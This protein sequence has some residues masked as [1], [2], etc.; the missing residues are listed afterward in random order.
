MP[1]FKKKFASFIGEAYDQQ[2]LS[3]SERNFIL[4]KSPATPNFYFLQKLHKNPSRPPGRPIIAGMD[5]LTSGLSEYLDRQLQR[6]VI[7]LPAYLKDSGHLLNL[8]LD[9]Q[10][11]KDMV[12]VT[13]DVSALYSNIPNTKGVKIVGDFLVLDS[14]MPEAQKLFIIDSLK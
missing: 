9:V 7:N 1:V 2:I 8:L 4:L 5:S 12:L 14:L 13:L 6:Y 10:W 3:K 11:E